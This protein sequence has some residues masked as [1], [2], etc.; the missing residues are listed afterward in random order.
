MPNQPDQAKQDLVRNKALGRGL[1]YPDA[2][3]EDRIVFLP[4]AT[5]ALLVL[6]SRNHNVRFLHHRDRGFT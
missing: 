6:L 3:S 2:F 4:R 1:L 5:S